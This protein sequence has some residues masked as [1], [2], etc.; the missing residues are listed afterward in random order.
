MKEQKSGAII[1][2]SAN[3]HWNGAWGQ[4]HSSAA[5]AGVDAITKVLATEWGP[6]G[7]RVCGLV[8][9]AIE[10]TEGF[11]RLGDFGNINNKERT[12]Q[13]FKKKSASSNKV[14]E[15][16]KAITPAQRFGKPEDIGYAAL[17]LGS[18]AAS[19]VS[20]SLLVVD[21]GVSLTMPNSFFMSP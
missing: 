13:A 12:N 2:I 17:F 11:E 10:G 1:N 8:P 4:V 16:M 3:L 21:G 19:Y 7:I 6:H 20:G 5:K 9:G 15:H 14:I 18:P